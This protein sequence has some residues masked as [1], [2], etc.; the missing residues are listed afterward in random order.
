MGQNAE[1]KS[2]IVAATVPTT[3]LTLRAE[4]EQIII[5]NTAGTLLIKYGTGVSDTSVT[6]P[7]KIGEITRIYRYTGIVT[8]IKSGSGTTTVFVTEIW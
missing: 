5:Y 1:V 7:I 3:L 6:E 4:R 2:Y 8:A